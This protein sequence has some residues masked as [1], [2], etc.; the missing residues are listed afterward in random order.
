MKDSREVDIKKLRRVIL[1]AFFAYFHKKK[2]RSMNLLTAKK[3]RKII[4]SN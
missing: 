3:M 2:V 1:Y 4:L